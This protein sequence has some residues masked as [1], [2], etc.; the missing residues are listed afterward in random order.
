[1]ARNDREVNYS[2]LR[3]FVD[4]IPTYNGDGNT[5]E[6]FIEHCDSLISNFGNENP[7]DNFNSFLLRAI[8]SK[9]VGNALILA[10]SRPEVRKWDDLKALLRLTFGDQRNLDCLVQDLMILQP[11]R[12]ESFSSFG[13]RIQKCRSSICS[14]LKSMNITPDEK[15]LQ[16]KNYD[17]LA[18]KTFIRGLSGRIQDM[19]RLRNPDSIELAIS[20]V[21]EEENFLLNQRQTSSFRNM[22]QKPSQR[23]QL[24][25]FP[26]PNLPFPNISNLP[27][28]QQYQPRPISNAFP[29]TFPQKTPQ[30][31]FPQHLQYNPPP[32]QQFP[33]QI[34][35]QFPS[36][37]IPV[38]PRPN[39]HTN[40]KF[41]TNKEVFGSR[42]VFRPTGQI[43]SNK[44]EPMST[45]S[46]FTQP[47]RNIT[48]Q[49][50]NIEQFE[51]SN[52]SQNEVLPETTVEYDPT[53][54]YA[55]SDYYPY[56]CEPSTSN[57]CNEHDN[58]L[59][60]EANFSTDQTQDETT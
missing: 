58:F 44:P 36:Q 53:C 59:E 22:A 8:I 56:P 50:H 9:L 12:N 60:Q 40:Q 10:G 34:R 52:Y 57:T 27:N 51:E 32:P 5:L 29:Q 6:I 46:R 26:R 54:A 21:L 30:Q 49:L 13:Q 19:V 39:Y 35:Q 2:L 45:T 48:S 20:Y 24:P 1:M 7:D 33:Q 11:F 47:R 28:Y 16:L 17:E 42:N 31:Y 18:L 23:P 4:T 25:S 15:I 55:N 14:K 43:P 3:L 41:L 37:S 38:Q